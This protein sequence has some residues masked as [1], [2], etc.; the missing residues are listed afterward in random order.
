MAKK[1]DADDGKLDVRQQELPGE[2]ASAELDLELLLSPALDGLAVWAAETLAA[3]R[4]LR[5]MGKNGKTGTS[6]YK[7]T[8]ACELVQ[9]LD[10]DPRGDGVESSPG[11]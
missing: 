10:Q 3:S 6:V 8:P 1:I 4:L 7:K 9:G 11:H 5:R 2:A